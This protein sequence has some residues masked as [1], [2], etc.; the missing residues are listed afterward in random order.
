MARLRRRLDHLQVIPIAE[1]LPSSWPRAIT[2]RSIDILRRRDLEALHAACE[3]ALVVRLCQHVHVVALQAHVNDPES[4]APR[5]DDRRI[6][7]RLVHVPPSQAAHRRHDSHHDV[8]PVLSLEVRPRLVPLP[9]PRTARL[10]PA[11]R[12]L[13]PRRNSDCWTCRLRDIAAMDLTLSCT[14]RLYIDWAQ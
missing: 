7:Q 2:Q 12:R 10:S 11:P 14:R 6:A 8:Q 3:C 13:P 1:Y 5:G 4:L 9:R